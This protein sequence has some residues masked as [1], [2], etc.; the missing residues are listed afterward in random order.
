MAR[1]IRYVTA[2]A[3][4]EARGLV[5]EVY[6]QMRADFGRVAE[7]LAVHSP[8]PGLLA[9]AWGVTRETL[10]AGRVP[11]GVKESIA[12][13]VSAVNRCPYCLDV[14]TTMARAA[15]YQEAARAVEGFSAR[16]P[17]AGAGA[18]PPDRPLA[19]LDHVAD[20][21]LAALLRWAAATRSPDAEILRAPPF[22][23]VE[24]PELVGVAV[25][26]H[27]LNRIV[28]AALPEDRKSVV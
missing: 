22:A 26:F 11:R 6:A 5:A 18:G 17:S 20:P 3:P 25:G 8:A 23:A 10:L 27:Y 16:A 2:V 21:R 19:S 9:G 24:A 13:T 14:H 4:R 28:S 1:R 12:S 15:G 7:P